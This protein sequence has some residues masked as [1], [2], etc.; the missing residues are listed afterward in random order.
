MD[1][2]RVMHEEAVAP[3]REHPER[4]AQLFGLG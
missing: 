1:R 2:G 3:L 4:L